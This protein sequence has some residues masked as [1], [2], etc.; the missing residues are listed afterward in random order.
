MI[1]SLISVYYY[2]MVIKQMYMK[3][4]QDPQGSTTGVERLKVPRVTTALLALL[5]GLVFLVG[6]YPAPIVHL[7]EE[8]T[9]L[10]FSNAATSLISAP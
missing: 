5:I 8:A 9:P 6:V 10:L 4:V 1:N 3:P 2:L 7:I